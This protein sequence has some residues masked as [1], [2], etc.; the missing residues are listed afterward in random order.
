[1]FGSWVELHA[2]MTHFPIALLLV[3]L[4]FDGAALLLKRPAWRDYGLA[5]L[6]LAVV[7]L[8][9]ALLTGYLAG[10]GMRRPPADFD[11]HWKAAVVTF[12]VSA[13]LLFWRVRTRART[14]RLPQFAMIGV[15]MVSAMAVGYTGHMG[16]AMVYG[17]RSDSEEVVVAPPAVAATP[18]ADKGSADKVAQA[19]GRMETAAG[20]LAKATDGLAA[21]AANPPKPQ[22]AAPSAPATINTAPLDD[23]TR[24]LERVAERFEAS[25]AKAEAALQAMQARGG[26][27]PAASAPPTVA[28]GSGVPSPT[29]GTTKSPATVAATPAATTAPAAPSGPDPQLVAAGQKLYYDDELG[30]TGC[31]KLSGKGGRSGPDLTFAGR[32]H[33]DIEWQIAHLKDPKSKIPGS[34]MPAYNDIPEANL[35]ALATFLVSLK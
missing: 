14:E 29:V 32:L 4:F 3:A 33:P 20:R 28:K 12:I 27:S 22:P 16:G 5:V 30:C 25:A 18:A 8:P 26:S 21:S 9:F 19:A 2:A 7:A 34:S 35:R 31:H 10:R 15:A 23:A 17:G 1:V 11:T 13:L 6:T 24:K